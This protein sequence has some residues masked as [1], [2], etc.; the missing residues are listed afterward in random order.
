VPSSTAQVNVGSQRDQYY[1]IPRIAYAT[2]T[3]SNPSTSITY[4][5][6]YRKLYCPNDL[7]EGFLT[8]SP[9]S[10]G[11]SWS[12]DQVSRSDFQRGNIFTPRILNIFDPASGTYSISI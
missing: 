7:A 1:I 10:T 11:L 4:S 3:D 2:I 9:H 8:S 12:S 6:Y 5:I